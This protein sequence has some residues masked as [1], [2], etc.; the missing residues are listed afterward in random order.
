MATPFLSESL[1]PAAGLRVEVTPIDGIT[2]SGVMEPAGVIFPAVINTL[3]IQET[4]SFG[5]YD[6][7]G[8]GSYSVRRAGSSSAQELR[9]LTLE[10]YAPHIGRDAAPPDFIQG[11]A[12]SWGELRAQL[13]SILHARFPVH[14]RGYVIADPKPLWAAPDWSFFVFE[15]TSSFDLDLNV[16]FRGLTRRLEPGQPQARYFSLELKGWRNVHEETQPV[17]Y[18]AGR[19]RGQRHLPLVHV[20]QGDETLAAIALKIYGR[21]SFWVDIRRY[22]ASLRAKNVAAHRPLR[23]YGVKSVVAPPVLY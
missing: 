10:I 13:E 7:V 17:A 16:T 1:V 2:P 8:A 9:S 20:V 23:E 15:E 4:A 6:S 5:D 12:T 22:N 3:E 18:K 14:V 19:S 21:S 11:G